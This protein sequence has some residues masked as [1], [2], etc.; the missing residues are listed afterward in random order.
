M[1]LL[2]DELEAKIQKDI[3]TPFLQEKYWRAK[4]HIDPVLQELYANIPEKKRISY[5]R[6]H[7]IKVLVKYLCDEINKANSMSVI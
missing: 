2:T 6:V 7:T 3:L 4:D 5:G 1:N